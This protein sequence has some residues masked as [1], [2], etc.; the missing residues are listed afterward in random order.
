MWEEWSYW[1]N[2]LPIVQNYV[3]D[4]T[5][6]QSEMIG[7]YL[8]KGSEFIEEGHFDIGDGVLGMK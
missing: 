4:L 1:K 3:C 5:A 2:L 6:G 7:L 8:C